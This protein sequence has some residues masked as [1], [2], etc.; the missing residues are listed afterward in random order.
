MHFMANNSL[1]CS[2]LCSVVLLFASSSVYAISSNDFRQY[3]IDNSRDRSFGQGHGDVDGDGDI[4]ICSGD[5]LYLNKNDALSQGENNWEKIGLPSALGD[6]LEMMDV[7]NDGTDEIIGVSAPNV[8]LAW[9]TDGNIRNWDTKQV[10]SGIRKDHASNEGQ[11]HA[12]LFGDGT[13]ELLLSEGEGGDTYHLLVPG[14]TP[15]DGNWDHYEINT[16]AGNEGLAAVDMDGDGFKDVVGSQGGE[17][18]KVAWYKNPGSPQ[19]HWDC[20]TVASENCKIDRPG[21]AD[22]DGDGDI[23]IWA[24]IEKCT[25]E[26]VKWYENPGDP[27]NDDWDAH[28]IGSAGGQG[29]SGSAADFD[30]DGD[31]DILSGSTT[32]QKVAIIWENDGSGNFSRVELPGN[33]DLHNAGDVSDLDGDGDWDIYGFGWD[34]DNMRVWENLMDVVAVTSPGVLRSHIAGNSFEKVRHNANG[35]ATDI[36]GRKVNRMTPAT[37]IYILRTPKNDGYKRIHLRLSE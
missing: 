9:P 29:H 4:D 7:D 37:G 8:I 32:D 16:N 19:S 28:T 30:G 27:T 22:L 21:A 6:A 36:R 17:F 20:Y 31:V 14:S 23:D 18:G 13:E 3:E 35:Y 12:D 33:G 15:Y 1:F 25:G 34:N 10:A 26:N 5:Y 11:C 24:V 2:C